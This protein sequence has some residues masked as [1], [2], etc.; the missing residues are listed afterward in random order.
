METFSQY[1]EKWL[2]QSTAHGLSNPL[3][4]MPAKRFRFLQPHEFNTIANGG[5]LVIGTTSDPISRNLF[6]NYQI[7]I[8]ERGEHCAYICFG[9]VEMTIAGSGP[10][11]RTALFPIC[12]KRA[13][14]HSNSEQIKA[15]VSEDEVW[16]FNP[17]LAAHLKGLS[18]N[19]E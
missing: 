15:S 4:K 1:L 14:L 11:S 18:R 2:K 5:A 19:A 8:R 13:T 16:Q 10:Q 3:V 9:S 6:K 12:L 7:R 17:V